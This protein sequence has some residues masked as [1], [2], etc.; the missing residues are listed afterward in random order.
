MNAQ[1][2]ETLAAA[3]DPL[4]G[5]PSP[6][7]WFY[8]YAMKSLYARYRKGEID[9]DTAKAEKQEIL[10][11][12]NALVYNHALYAA[13]SAQYQEFV[14][15]GGKYVHEIK[16]ALESHADAFSL[17]RLALGLYGAL[18]GDNT[19]AETYIKKMEEMEND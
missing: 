9:K 16:N 11:R 15:L 7:D 18:T 3:G 6:E 4:P 8:W 17:M 2:I 14:R 5:H 1:E 13:H 12:Y 19:T 10:Q